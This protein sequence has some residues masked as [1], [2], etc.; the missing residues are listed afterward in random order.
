MELI[1]S[2]LNSGTGAERA[3]ALFSP[4]IAL[5]WNEHLPELEHST[6]EHNA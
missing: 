4:M 3:D 5:Y 2:Q 1:I 6:P